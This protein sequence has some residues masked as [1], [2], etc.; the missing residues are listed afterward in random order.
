MVVKRLIAV[1]GCIGLLAG[2]VGLYGF[3]R[4][5][6]YEQVVRGGTPSTDFIEAMLARRHY[7]FTIISGLVAL[8]F[9]V[10]DIRSLTTHVQTTHPNEPQ[11]KDHP[12]GFLAVRARRYFLVVA[13]IAYVPIFFLT[14]GMK[15]GDRYPLTQTASVLFLILFA[16]SRR[17]LNK[18]L[19]LLFSKST[20]V[21]E[22][23]LDSFIQG[24]AVQR[25]NEQGGR[26]R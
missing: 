9:A 15:F 11:P 23:V 25:R 17:P 1:L 13:V 10:V 7:R 21:A 22:D 6:D 19:F 26:S 14:M 3:I 2:L 16:V 24:Q 20:E 18:T 8:V 4:T 5:G 12:L